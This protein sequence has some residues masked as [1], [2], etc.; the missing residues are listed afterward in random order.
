V[1]L[2]GKVKYESAEAGFDVRPLPDGWTAE[3]EKMPGR[4]LRRT[5]RRRL[6]SPGKRL[7]G[8]S[9]LVSGKHVAVD[10]SNPQACV[11]RK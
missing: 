5:A 6:G 1:I 7:R 3:Q 2:G 9:P 4:P 8:N 10:E 11:H